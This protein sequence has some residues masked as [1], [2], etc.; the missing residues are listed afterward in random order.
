M[1]LERRGCLTLFTAFS[2]EQVCSEGRGREGA[3]VQTPLPT[4]NP[5]PPP[6]RSGRCTCSIG[7]ESSGRWCGSCWTAR[8][9]TFTWQGEP[10]PLGGGARRP[11]EGSQPH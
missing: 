3:R 8:A 10:G 9:P 11:S 6:Y 1:E 7:S 4:P 5:L 2:R